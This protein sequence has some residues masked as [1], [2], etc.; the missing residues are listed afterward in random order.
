MRNRP[1]FCK[2]KLT[3]LFGIFC[4]AAVLRFWNFH[5]RLVLYSDSARDA[6]VGYAAVKYRQF[7]LTG[8]FSSA[9]PFV[10]G[11]VFYYFIMLSYVL[12]P[13]LTF[14]PWYGVAFLSLFLVFIVS[15]AA[16]RVKG[17]TAGMITAT[18]A[19]VSPA[20]VFRSLSLTQHSLVGV[21]TALVLLAT[22][23]YGQ[24][25]RTRWIFLL[26]IF[27]G[28]ALSL[29]YQAA[30]LLIAGTI[31]LAIHRR[32]VR[33][34]IID[35]AA[36]VV[37]IIIPLLPLLYWDSKQQWANLR[38]LLDYLFIG[39][40][41]IFVSRRWLTFITD[42]I[43]E[44]WGNISGGSHILGL[45]SLLIVGVML[46]RYALKRKYSVEFVWILLI[47]ILQVVAIR[48][49]RG[50][51]FEG[52]LI[53]LHPFV[54]FLSGWAISE[55]LK[56][57]KLKLAAAAVFVLFTAGSLRSSIKIV[58]W[59]DNITKHLESILSGISQKY[60]Y[61]KVN[62]YDF[63]YS[64]SEFSYSLSYLL[65]Q[66]HSVSQDGVPIGICL[67][68]CPEDNTAWV[69]DRVQYMDKGYEVVELFD[70]PENIGDTSLWTD[71]SAMNTLKEVGF[72]WREKPLQS[73][74][75]L[76]QFIVNDIL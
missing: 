23:Y 5:N 57:E 11:P 25:K 4:L 18:L 1:K 74:F 33:R 67:W 71:V 55:F 50:E 8:S 64:S 20:Q 3:I 16:Y 30:T 49:Y 15:F 24:T 29:H 47:F 34:I 62:P 45:V 46:L 14:G 76:K 31:A 63:Q 51:L 52:Y 10:F 59:N 48:Y 9:G 61:S 54:L 35:I 19:A 40:Y 17:W 68:G 36:Y 53:A 39:Q 69:I 28:L 73:N 60:A 75:S 37:G 7:P 66:K 12:L 42:F 72:W 32:H 6:L 26:G 13:S 58:S 22:I 41:R 27:V 2:I 38:N 65:E 44:T 70:V 56:I 21:F 43:P